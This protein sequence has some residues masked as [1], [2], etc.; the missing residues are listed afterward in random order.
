MQLQEKQDEI[1]DELVAL[2]GE[3]HLALA[4]ILAREVRIFPV[5]FAV[6]E[7]VVQPSAEL[8]REA[9]LIF[10][11]KDKDQ[12]NDAN[13]DRVDHVGREVH[14]S[15]H[16]AVLVDHQ[17]KGNAAEGVDCDLKN[18]KNVEADK[19]PKNVE[20]TNDVGACLDAE[21]AATP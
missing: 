8:L 17:Q 21:A 10:A 1:A 6:C 2:H 7:R 19:Q 9:L 3:E 11:P 15:L 20:A 16:F 5:H 18:V 13:D 12:A 4:V 14:E